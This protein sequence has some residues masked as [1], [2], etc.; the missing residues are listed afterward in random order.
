MT[1]RSRAATPSP[2]RRP[3]PSVASPASDFPPPASAARPDGPERPAA[4]PGDAEPHD[5]EPEERGRGG[6]R[7]LIR[8]VAIVAGIIMAVLACWQDPL[9]AL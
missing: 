5:A 4:E 9:Y 3:G 7:R 2:W 1:E 6:S 8:W